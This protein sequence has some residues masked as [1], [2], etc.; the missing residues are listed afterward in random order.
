VES[1]RKAISRKLKSSGSELVRKAA[2]H[3]RRPSLQA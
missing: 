2:L 3:G 1:H